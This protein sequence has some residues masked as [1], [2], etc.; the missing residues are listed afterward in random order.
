MERLFVMLWRRL[1]CLEFDTLQRLFLRL[2]W[3]L[4]W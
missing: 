1:A 3:E 2:D 4:E